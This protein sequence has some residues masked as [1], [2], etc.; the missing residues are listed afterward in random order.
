MHYLAGVVVA[1]RVKNPAV[2]ETRRDVA[3]K[4]ITKV[5]S[6]AILSKRTLREI[7]ILR[8]VGVSASHSLRPAVVSS[9]GTKT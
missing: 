5:F 1:A 8:C 6:K 9:T 7:K 4:K 2:P 3:I